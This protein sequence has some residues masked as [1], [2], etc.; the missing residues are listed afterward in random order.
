MSEIIVLSKDDLK[1]LI[2]EISYKAGKASATE[3][4]SQIEKQQ[5]DKIS[6]EEALSLLDVKPDKLAKLREN[7]EIVYYAGTRPYLYSRKSIEEYL[8]SLTIPSSKFVKN[9]A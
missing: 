5:D 4:L 2:H 8:I 9:G 1:S 7:R 3:V 6:K